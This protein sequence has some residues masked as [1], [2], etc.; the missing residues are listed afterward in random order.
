MNDNSDNSARPS[1]PYGRWAGLTALLFGEFIAISLRYDAA[2]VPADRPWHGLVANAGVLSRIGVAIALAV[3]LLA[4]P[5]WFRELRLSSRWLKR[6]PHFFLRVL[7][8]LAAFF[9]FFG[10]SA[11]VLEG[12]NSSPS[13]DSV[14]FA[15]WFASGMATLVFWAI[16]ALP[17]GLWIRLVKQSWGRVLAGSALGLAASAAGLLARDQWKL[18][19]K[20]TLLTVADMLRLVS[21]DVVCKPDT[22][23]VG[24]SE[25]EVGISPECSGYEGM[26][27][28]SF[29]V[30][31]AL[32]VLRRDFRFPRS[33]AL[34]PI[35]MVLMWVANA[36]RITAL[37]M[38][39]QAAI[40]TL[41][42]AGSIRWRVGFCFSSSAWG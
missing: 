29:L 24:T 26:G 23:V 21:S 14:F 12:E 30:L 22:F 10:T 2:T 37:V 6:P 19:S 5:V 41:Q 7:G 27:L 40:L 17:V 8:N 11:V 39:E 36:V 15:A 16:A 25:F 3:M 35:A 20:W 31:V 38:M 18:L 28:I 33:F 42:S 13:A 1:I 32:F 9:C 4:G 34:V